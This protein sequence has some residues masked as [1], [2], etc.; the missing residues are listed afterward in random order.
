MKLSEYWKVFDG[1]SSTASDQSRKLAFAGIAV[2]WIFQV[3]TEE[4]PGLDPIQ[5]WILLLLCISLGADLIQY[6]YASIAWS[7]FCKHHE[8]KLDNELDD[9]E[10]RA[11]DWINLPTWLFF[12]IKIVSVIVGYV[13]LG[14]DLISRLPP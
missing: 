13:F 2:V 6:V 4:N 10:L 12:W 14:L 7:A 5:A 1:F 3:G 8:R 9:P 11:P